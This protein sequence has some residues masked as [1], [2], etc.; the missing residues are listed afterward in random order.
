MI[1]H[2]PFCVTARLMAGVKVGDGFISIGFSPRPGDEGRTRFQYHID[3]GHREY[4]NDD[5]QSGRFVS[6]TLQTGMED[7]LS[8]LDAASEAVEP[9][10]ERG[11]NA[12]LFPD[13]VCEWAYQNAD[14]LACLRCEIEET[15]NLI[16]D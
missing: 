13:W 10:R 2:A 11:K 15:P 14:D 8:F 16:T 9:G 7:L 4:S 3:S 5:L 1:L 12:D 6:R